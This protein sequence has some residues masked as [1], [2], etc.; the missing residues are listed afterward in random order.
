M[1]A[2]RREKVI[3]RCII[4][5]VGEDKREWF[6]EWSSVVDAPLTYGM[7][8]EGLA[9]HVRYNHGQAGIDEL[10]ARMERVDKRGHSMNLDAWEL[11]HGGDL[12]CVEYITSGN[13]AGVGE[14]TL[15]NVQIIAM[16]C[17]RT[18]DITGTDPH[19]DDGE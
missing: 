6:M 1:D 4:K 5:L 3:G 2:T 7:N 14:T 13:R 18:G 9:D 11:K 17:E 8:L 15:T 12:E 16:Y 10:P 19:E